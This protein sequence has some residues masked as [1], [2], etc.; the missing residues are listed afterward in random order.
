MFAFPTGAVWFFG[1]E[2]NQLCSL[3][4]GITSGSTISFRHSPILRKGVQLRA[5]TCPWGIWATGKPRWLLLKPSEFLKALKSLLQTSTCR[6]GIKF[7]FRLWAP[8]DW[9][10]SVLFFHLKKQSPFCWMFMSILY[11]FLCEFQ[12]MDLILW[13]LYKFS[14]KPMTPKFK[15]H[16]VEAE[17]G[18]SHT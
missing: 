9:I 8:C 16:I 6:R 3:V 14:V 13:I 10:H 7:I 11:E 17:G 4:R 18:S 2:M 1:V 15:F 12:I 5:G